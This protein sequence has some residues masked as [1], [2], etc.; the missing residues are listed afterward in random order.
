MSVKWRGELT[1]DRL[2][3]A[4]GQTLVVEGG[5]D[6]AEEGSLGVER[7]FR[8]LNDLLLHLLNGHL[9]VLVSH[10]DGDE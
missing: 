4:T 6:D 2:V 10:G 7:D 5:L 3:K 8:L 1:L 9:S